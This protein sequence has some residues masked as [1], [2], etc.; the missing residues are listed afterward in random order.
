MQ[1][2][3]NIATKQNNFVLNSIEYF[4]ALQSLENEIKDFGIDAEIVKCTIEDVPR[5]INSN[6]IIFMSDNVY[7]PDDFLNSC[8]SLNN[9]F[10]SAGVFCGPVFTNINLIT[11][12]NDIL[13]YSKSYYSYNLDFGSSELSN[14]TGEDFNYPSLIGCA[15]T[16]KAY[17]EI[18]YSPTISSRH[19]TIDNKLFISNISKRYEIYYARNLSKAINLLKEDFSISKLSDY[20]YELGY[21]DGLL[22]LNKSLKDKHQE[23][24]HRFVESPEIFDNEMPRWLFDSSPDKDGEYLES[25]VLMKCKYQ[26]GFYEGMLGKKLI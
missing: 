4:P 18:G 9:L 14:I 21:Q 20:Y 19:K 11:Y 1:K 12:N 24:W 3:D 23:L 5:R 8:I 17:N 16:G 26:I 25:L 22:L 13:R 2:K 10:R 7:L 15:I 6:L